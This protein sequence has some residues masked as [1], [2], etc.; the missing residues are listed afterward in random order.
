MAPAGED[1]AKGK[2]SNEPGSSG[3]TTIDVNAVLISAR[4]KVQFGT[5]GG[6]RTHNLLIK[7]QLLYH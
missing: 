3:V 1:V 4:A 6:A 5:Q 2:G 7:S